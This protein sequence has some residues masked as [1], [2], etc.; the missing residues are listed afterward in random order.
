MRILIHFATEAIGHS[1]LYVV[2]FVAFKATLVVEPDPEVVATNVIRN[3]YLGRELAVLSASVKEV[4]T[5]GKDLFDS[6]AHVY[7]LGG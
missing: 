5:D 4:V 2:G 1:D 3:V 6:A 7:L